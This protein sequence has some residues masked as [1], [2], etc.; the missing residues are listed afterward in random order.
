MNEFDE[1]GKCCSLA[2]QVTQWNSRCRLSASSFLKI[3]T[4]QPYCI[5][6]LVTAQLHFANSSQNS[7]NFGVARIAHIAACIV[8]DVAR[9]SCGT[10]IIVIGVACVAYIAACVGFEWTETVLKYCYIAVDVTI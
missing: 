3:P 9:V 6:K 2:N 8:F 4:T 7:V 10:A 5:E 1:S